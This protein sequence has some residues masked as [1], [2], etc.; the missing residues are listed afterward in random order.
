MDRKMIRFAVVIGMAL[1]CSGCSLITPR[2]KLERD[3]AYESEQTARQDRFYERQQEYA[4]T[5]A[6]IAQTPVINIRTPDTVLPDG[7][8]IKGTTVVVNREID[9][10][11]FRQFENQPTF[12]ER[13]TMQAISEVGATLRTAVPFAGAGWA[14]YQQRQ[15]QEA[16]Y[17]HQTAR[18]Q[19]MAEMYGNLEGGQ[20][21]VISGSYN[22]ESASSEE[23]NSTAYGDQSGNGEIGRIG[24]DTVGSHNPETTTTSYGDQ[25]GNGEIGRIGDETSGSYNPTETTT[26]TTTEAPVTPIVPTVVQPHVVAPVVP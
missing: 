25:S 15:V 11:P 4:E 17:A 10:P 22:S 23:T 3:R 5:V 13:V 6:T 1:L 9:I 24:S 2:A 7:T 16:Q 21:T 18:D 8:V 14:T 26:T 20:S 12:G 19:S